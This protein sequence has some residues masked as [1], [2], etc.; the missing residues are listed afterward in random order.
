MLLLMLVSVEEIGIEISQVREMALSVVES[1]QSS[2][3]ASA[4]KVIK[5]SS[6]AALV[7]SLK[8]AYKH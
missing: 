4:T 5:V 7:F 2:R 1:G 6:F 8:Y 3:A